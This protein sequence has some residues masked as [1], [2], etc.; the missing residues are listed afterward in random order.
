M[1]EELQAL[2]GDTDV[3]A[4]ARVPAAT[5]LASLAHGSRARAARVGT[6]EVVTALL[7]VLEQQ[8]ERWH[9]SE[10]EQHSKRAR[11]EPAAGGAGHDDAYAVVTTLGADDQQQAEAEAAVAAAS[12]ACLR[13]L[14]EAGLPLASLGQRGLRGCVQALLPLLQPCESGMERYGYTVVTDAAAVLGCLGSA[15][16][17]SER[18]E[19]CG[20]LTALLASLAKMKVATAPAA[21]ATSATGAAAA[22]THG[23]AGGSAA[24]SME[25][26]QGLGAAAVSRAPAAAHAAGVSAISAGVRST[27]PPPETLGALHAYL[28]TLAPM[29]RQSRNAAL[30]LY[31]C[32]LAS[33]QRV[34]DWLQ[35]SYLRFEPE[36]HLLALEW[37]VFAPDVCVLLPGLLFLLQVFSCPPLYPCFVPN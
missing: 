18:L 26:V 5:A 31:R 24:E 37:C 3:P 36:L 16:Q 28:Q 35:A 6:S 11:R 20:A 10:M 19:S 13:T 23:A 1:L 12:C 22:A 8:N 30:M 4:A 17:D 33:G 14:G 29:T 25:D 7:D 32:H 27:L 2:L 9:R 34:V 21:T 15:P